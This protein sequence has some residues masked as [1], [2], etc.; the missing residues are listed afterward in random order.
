MG[1]GARFEID[2]TVG[3]VYLVSRFNK[4]WGV[5]RPIIYLV[6]DVY[7][8]LIVGMHVGLDHPS[9]NGVM[10]AIMNTTQNKIEF[11]KEYSIEITEGKW[12]SAH[13]PE[14]FLADRGEALY[15]GAT[16]FIEGINVSVDHTAS[17]RADMKGTIERSFASLDAALKPFLPGYIETDFQER[18]AKDPRKQAALTVEQY[19]KIIIYF[20][21]HHNSRYMKE[22]KRNKEMIEQDVS[23]IPTELWQWGIKNR[24]G[25]LRSFP[26][27]FVRF[28]LLPRAQATVTQ[29]G[30]KFKKMHY[31]C[32]TAI[33]EQWFSKA[34]IKGN[35]KV[36][37]A[38]NPRN[39]NH[40][41]IIMVGEEKIE[42]CELLEKDNIYRDRW[43][44][45][46]EN[47]W[48]QERKRVRQ[49][50]HEQLQEKI[51][52]IAEIES[53]TQEA[54]KTEIKQSKDNDKTKNIRMNRALEKAAGN[55]EN[56]KG[57]QVPPTS[58]APVRYTEA[59]KGS[60]EEM[61]R[62]RKKE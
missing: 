23:P 22:Y 20:I 49:K 51:N 50:E 13:V 31:T 43:L 16:S 39:L 32:N 3:N 53:V 18:G 44:E 10:M 38:Y 36:Q 19:T 7:S 15:K 14:R 37:I 17:Y 30:I 8:R 11:C 61:F 42:K 28:C 27:E 24:S 29:L 35:W 46:I 33:T 6:I 55:F 9:W 58:T 60:L 4:G 54:K 45:E 1:P 2:A 21:L 52:F 59:R 34:A 41:Y 62:R 48:E 57:K 12:P 56:S 47:L 40:I 5:G 25:K 26:Q